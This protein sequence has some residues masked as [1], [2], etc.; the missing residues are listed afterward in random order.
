MN[1]TLEKFCGLRQTGN[2]GGGDIWV[3]L[4]SDFGNLGKYGSNGSLVKIR[5]EVWDWEYRT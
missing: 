4:M 1:G 5:E 2:V 3:K